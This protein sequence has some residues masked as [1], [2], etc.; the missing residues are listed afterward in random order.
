MKVFDFGLVLVVF[1]LVVALMPQYLSFLIISL[2][3]GSLLMIPVLVLE[4]CSRSTRS[5]W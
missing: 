2:V 3:P 1:G 5:M 4:R